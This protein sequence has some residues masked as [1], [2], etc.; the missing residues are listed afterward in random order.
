MC[1]KNS[2]S[3]LSCLKQLRPRSDGG[4]G[5]VYNPP[6]AKWL[7]K[8]QQ[9]RVQAHEIPQ[10]GSQNVIIRSWAI[11]QTEGPSQRSRRNFDKGGSMPDWRRKRQIQESQRQ[12]TNWN[13]DPS[14]ACANRI[15]TSRNCPVC[16][17]NCKVEAADEYCELNAKKSW[18]RQRLTRNNQHG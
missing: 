17:S 2:A 6:S 10:I 15:L 13:R 8:P 4:K 3:L 7:K 18:T 14:A 1:K 12:K 5:A 16:Y 11:Q 9:S